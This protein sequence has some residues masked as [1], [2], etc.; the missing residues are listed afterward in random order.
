V[1]TSPF[2]ESQ[3]KYVSAILINYKDVPGCRKRSGSIYLC[4]T[5]GF[6][7][8]RG[9]EIDIACGIGIIKQIQEAKSIIPVLLLS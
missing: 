3:T 2:T 1:K 9:P 7:D 8:T 5:P 6:I 4:D